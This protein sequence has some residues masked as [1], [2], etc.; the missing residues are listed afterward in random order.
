MKE[1][2]LVEM[3]TGI[4]KNVVNSNIKKDNNYDTRATE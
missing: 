2:Q 3:N 4:A 1:T